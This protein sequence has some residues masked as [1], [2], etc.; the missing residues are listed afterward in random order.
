MTQLFSVLSAEEK[1]RIQKRV[2]VM[3]Q[4]SEEKV[5]E[6]FPVWEA[7]IL[8]GLLKLVRNRIRYNALYNFILQKPIPIESIEAYV[9]DSTAKFD[10]DEIMHFG[11]G[12][13]SILIP[14]KK[15]AIAMLLSRDL[16]CK[17]SSVLKGLTLFFGLYGYKLKQ[18]DYPALK[19]WKA[20]SAFFLAKKSDF[21]ALCSG[22]IQYAI[23]DI[24]LL[25]DILKVDPMIVLAYSD[26][27][28]TS[29]DNSTGLMQRITLPIFLSVMAVVLVGAFTIWYTSFRSDNDTENVTETEE[30]I[31]LD[32]LSKLNDSL[33]QAVLDSNRLKSDSLITLVWPNGKPFDISKT[34]VLVSVHQYLLDSTQLESAEFS[35]KELQFDNQTDL[36]LDSNDLVFKRL[37]EGLYSFK[38]VQV[39]LVVNSGKSDRSSLKRGFVLKNRLVGEGVVPARIEVKS[40]DPSVSFSDS[41]S[42]VYMVLTKKPLLK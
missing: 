6:L 9:G 2:A 23:S 19:D 26:E 16:G 39:K 21:N 24:L 3:L 28:E 15:S 18:T 42:E 7:I 37:A 29:A 17:S 22:K 10:L 27:S 8:G 31:P 40:D 1:L 35:L 25:S 5:A 34:S 20:Y 38:D 14:D 11:E 13:M 4:E 30:I 33:T 41:D 36:L 32:S 12:M